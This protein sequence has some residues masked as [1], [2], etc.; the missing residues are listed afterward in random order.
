MAFT[1]TAATGGYIYW[2]THVLNEYRTTKD[3]E[4]L[5]V[6]YERAYRASENLPQPRITSIEA[7]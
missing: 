6:D 5:Q 3:V 1:G 7:A 2:N 4:R